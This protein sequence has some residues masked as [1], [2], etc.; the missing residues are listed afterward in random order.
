MKV[1]FLDFDGVLNN[2]DFLMAACQEHKGRRGETEFWVAMIDPECVERLNGVVRRTG[3]AVVISS[4]WR[5]GR[6]RQD[7]QHYLDL[8]GFKYSVLG[9]T[10]SIGKAGR[11]RGDEIQLWLDRAT[12]K[13]GEIESFAIIDDDSDM[14]HLMPRLVNTSFKVGLQ[15]EHVEQLVSLLGEPDA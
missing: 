10:P 5:I 3:C 15:D 7:L 12:N 1:L 14:G 6:N 4:S 13:Y 8:T 2:Q 9:C 11:I